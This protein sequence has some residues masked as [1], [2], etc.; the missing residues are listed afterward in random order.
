VPVDLRVH[1]AR[2]LDDRVPAD[3]V[4]EW[5]DQNVR[6]RGARGFDRE[7][8]VGDE[9]AGPLGAEGKGNRRLEAEERHGPD[10]GLQK[11]RG[12]ATRRRRYR[13]HD[14]LGALTAKGREEA[15]DETIDVGGCDVHVGRVVLRPYRHRGGGRCR[16][17]RAVCQV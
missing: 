2:P 11:L 5:L 17:S 15:R 9:V 8:H 6:T 7:V 1:A 4:G 3:W 16:R 12:R 10:G 13:N 14:L